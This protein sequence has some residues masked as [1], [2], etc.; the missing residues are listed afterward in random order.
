MVCLLQDRLLETAESKD[1]QIWGVCVNWRSL[2][3]YALK[4]R[5]NGSVKKLWDAHVQSHHIFFYTCK[6]HRLANDNYFFIHLNYFIKSRVNILIGLYRLIAYWFIHLFVLIW[7]LVWHSASPHLNWACCYN[8]EILLFWEKFSSPG[9][10][11]ILCF[12]SPPLVPHCKNWNGST[13]PDSQH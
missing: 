1:I 10:R 2:F 6:T 9:H 12:P 11:C 7:V 3:K 4:S 13:L 5:F 8:V